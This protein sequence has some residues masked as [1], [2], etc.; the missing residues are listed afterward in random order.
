MLLLH[1]PNML[2]YEKATQ[3]RRQQKCTFYQVEST[4]GHQEMYSITSNKQ[5]ALS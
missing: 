1:I 4:T 3:R 2:Q 5:R